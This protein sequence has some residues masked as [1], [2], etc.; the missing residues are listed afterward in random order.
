MISFK[1]SENFHKNASHNHQILKPKFCSLGK[2]KTPDNFPYKKKLDLK[3]LI[4][5]N[6]LLYFEPFGKIC[7]IIS[8]INQIMVMK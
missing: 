7:V 4:I 1:T 6:Y 8:I 2:I 5:K 3:K